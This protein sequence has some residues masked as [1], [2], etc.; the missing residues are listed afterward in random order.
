M[1]ITLSMIH[2]PR[3]ARQLEYGTCAIL[4]SVLTALTVGLRKGCLDSDSGI[5]PHLNRIQEVFGNIMQGYK[6]F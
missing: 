2:K 1:T 3:R 5:G 4:L 6:V